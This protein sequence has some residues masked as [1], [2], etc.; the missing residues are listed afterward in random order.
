[1][2][3]KLD[4]FIEQSNNCPM[5]EPCPLCYKCQV[6]ASHLYLQCAEC[7]LEFCAHN[8]K[9]RTMMI[10]RENFAVALSKEAQECIEC[11]GEASK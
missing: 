8:D 2:S 10:R 7:P 3:S 1:M 9:Q 5:Y 4:I 11:K 6:K